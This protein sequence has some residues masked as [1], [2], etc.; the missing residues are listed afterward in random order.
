VVTII[1]CLK[2]YIEKDG[3]LPDAYYLLGLMYDMYVGGRREEGG[4]RRRERGGRDRRGRGK[5]EGGG[6]KIKGNNFQSLDYSVSNFFS[7][8]GQAGKPKFISTA[9]CR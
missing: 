7:G 2:A 5:M 4:G 6:L 1:Q 8:P 3:T 9:C